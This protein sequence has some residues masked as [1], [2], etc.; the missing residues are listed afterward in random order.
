MAN[1]ASEQNP[2]KKVSDE[3]GMRRILE[4]LISARSLLTI[5]IG[6]DEHNF[7]S[8]AVLAVYPQE[9][10]FVLDELNPLAGH[11]KLQEHETLKVYALLKGVKVYFS[12][13]VRKVSVKDEISYY[14]FSFPD[15]IYYA[16][17][18]DH[19]RVHVTGTDEN[20]IRLND[21]EGRLLDLSLGGIGALFPAESKIDV[22]DTIMNAQIQ[23]PGGHFIHCSLE[24]CNRMHFDD[25]RLTRIGAKFIDLEKERE[26]QIQ[27]IIT[28][29]ER[30]EMRL[31][32]KE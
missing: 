24:I 22:G 3:R 17:Q 10:Q 2:D 25:K 13:R 29:F 30:E 20:T 26:R 14:V 27:R 4:G 5:F 1:P 6:D 12:A 28:Y 23:L 11:K 32:P 15:F 21:A 9:K 16:Q 19:Y 8:S 18:R 7:Y 31:K